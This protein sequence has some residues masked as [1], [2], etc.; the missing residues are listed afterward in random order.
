[1]KK[2]TAADIMNMNVKQMCM[3]W[4]FITG[5]ILA[6]S[7]E[8]HAQNTF[9]T[10]N[11]YW[12]VPGNWSLGHAPTNGENVLVGINARL[13]NATATVGTCVITNSAIVTFSSIAARLN[14]QDVLVVGTAKLTHSLNSATTTNSLGGWDPDARVY[15]VCTNF[16]LGPSAMVDANSV[17][18]QGAYAATGYGP[19]RGTGHPTTGR[20][21][22][23][24]HGGTG[25]AGTFSG[26]IVNDSTNAPAQPGSSG[27]GLWNGAGGNGGGLVRLDVAAT[28]TLNGTVSVNGAPPPSSIYSGGGAGGGIY[29][30]CGTLG[31]TGTVSAIG[32]VGGAADCGC[33]GGGRIAVIAAASAGWTGIYRVDGGYTAGTGGSGQSGP[34]YLSGASKPASIPVGINWHVYGITN[35]VSDSLTVSNATLVLEEKGV[36]IHIISNLVV[37]SNSTL[38]VGHDGDAETVAVQVDGDLIVT[39]S[40]SVFL[41]YSGATN[42]VVTNGAV[43]TV[44]GVMRIA[45]TLSLYSN[46]TNGGSARVNAAGVEVAPAGSIVALGFAPSLGGSGRGT[47][48]GGN[49]G[50]TTCGGGGGYGGLGGNGANGGAG[51]GMYGSSNAPV[52]AGSSGGSFK[53][54]YMGARGGGA[55]RLDAGAGTIRV[56]GTVSADATATTAGNYCGGG[57]GGSVYLTC[58]TLTGVGTLSAKGSGGV[59]GGGGGGGGRIAVIYSSA[60]SFSGPMTAAQGTGNVNGQT[61]TVVVLLQSVGTYLLDVRGVPGNYGAPSPYGNGVNSVTA[62]IT[63][64]NTVASPADEVAGVRHVCTGWTLT[65]TLGAVASGVTTQSVFQMTTNLFQTWFWYNEYFLTT[66]AG[67]NGTVNNTGWYSNGV[68][69]TV[70]AS[71]LAGYH[72]SQWTGADVPA[73]SQFVNPLQLTMSRLLQ[74]EAH[75]AADTPQTKT[76]SGSGNWASD[77][78][79]SP[80]GM[81]GAADSA[82][83]ASGTVT[84]SDPVQLNALTVNGTLVFDTTNAILNA[85][86]TVTVTGTVTHSVQTAT[87]APWVMDNL[88]HIVAS[89]ITVNTGAVIDVSGKGFAA[90]ASLN[91]FGPGYGTS[92]GVNAGGSGASHGG[93][94]GNGQNNLQTG[95][96]YDSSNAP[97]L[98]GS[99]GGGNTSGAY[100][101]GTGGGYVWLDVQNGRLTVNGSILANGNTGGAWSGGGSGGG[102]Y[103]NCLYLAGTGQIRAGGGAGTGSGGGG[104]G[105][106][107]AVRS[108]SHREWSGTLDV[109]SSVAGGAGAGSG[110]AGGSGTVVWDQ[111]PAS[112]VI[113]L[114]R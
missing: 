57:S 58:G 27:G 47:G 70:T 76:W 17:G 2:I 3:V 97:A 59:L 113:Y 87:N 16:T 80:A 22:G 91:G 43:L 93:V 66:S 99:G 68:S 8:A 35:W 7:P 25:G 51:G 36:Q 74:V 106:R 18:Y 32:A 52:D 54:T 10:T 111:I 94:G 26:G 56:D 82:T 39:N 100:S 72:F 37:C 108:F 33:G 105:G 46:P 65:N 50:G 23:G 20:G 28:L 64:T 102:I 1:M 81:P 67:T 48:A 62:G 90:P 112:G 34:L 83:I 71:P 6:L 14:A 31:G 101:G 95:G 13:T 61:G 60:N 55:V 29:I 24:G 75:F 107:I 4:I 30:T 69:V 96:V 12:D 73:G 44:G 86:G 78:N 103:L 98:P 42:A 89:N 92:A 21:A 9:T 110:T 104:G 53:S 45:A 40:G 5:V 85:A 38:S 114:L 79:W 19:G 49:G 11:G 77:T 15:V 109:S 88:V 84:L 63:V 41:V